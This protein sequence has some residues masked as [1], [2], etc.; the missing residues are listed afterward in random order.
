VGSCENGN[1]PSGSDAT[2]LVTYYSLKSYKKCSLLKFLNQNMF[3]F[4]L[5]NADQR[6]CSSRYFYDRFLVC[7]S[8]PKRKDRPRIAWKMTDRQ[9]S[10]KLQLSC[11]GNQ[12]RFRKSQ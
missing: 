3:S 8:G 9:K 12:E 2:E 1:K 7:F 4:Q 6:I 10:G 11:E 5:C